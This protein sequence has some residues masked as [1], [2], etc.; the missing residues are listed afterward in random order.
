MPTKSAS[1]DARRADV[2]GF[3]CRSITAMGSALPV[4]VQSGDLISASKSGHR[5]D[6]GLTIAPQ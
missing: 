6:V 4:L 1:S 3:E 2:T 5:V